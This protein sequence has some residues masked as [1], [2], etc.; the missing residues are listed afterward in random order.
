[1]SLPT[2]LAWPLRGLLLVLVSM[3]SIRV[4]AQ[5]CADPGLQS[6]LRVFEAYNDVTATCEVAPLS[7]GDVEFVHISYDDFPGIYSFVSTHPAFL[8]W[9]VYLSP[10]MVHVA[11]LMREVERSPSEFWIIDVDD[12]G[13]VEFG[14]L[15]ELLGDDHL[16]SEFLTG[17]REVIELLANHPSRSGAETVAPLVSDEGGELDWYEKSVQGCIRGVLS[18]W[19]TSE[20]PDD[21][22]ARGYCECI[23]DKVA[24]DPDRIADMFDVSS[25]G[26]SDL[27]EGCMDV[28]M[29]GLSGFTMDEVD[30]SEMQDALKRGYMRGCL[31]EAEVLLDDLGFG[32]EGIAEEYCSCMYDHLRTQPSFTMSDFEDENSVVMTEI[33]AAC[34][35][36]L[37]GEAPLN[38]AQYWNQMAGCRGV[39]STPFLVNSAGEVRIKVAF[40]EVEKYLTLDSG[41][42][43]VILSEELAR[44]LKMSGDIGPGD[45]LGLEMFVLADGTEVAVE[46]YRVREMRVGSCVV[47]DFIVGVMEEGGMLLGMGYLGLFDAWELDQSTQTLRTTH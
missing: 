40:G 6:V 35:H 43:E 14:R 34:S 37:T 10:E 45:Y 27:I 25:E 41:C 29:P 38:A 15:L 30:G 31:R 19:G 33:D 26:F 36:I 13:D 23:A 47:N 46:K 22:N 18:E 4:G 9:K 32:G 44:D 20:I 17:T 11:G 3:S 24:A 12:D 39:R 1:M 28:L 2:M 16:E 21:L 42:S 7:T 5:S 8:R